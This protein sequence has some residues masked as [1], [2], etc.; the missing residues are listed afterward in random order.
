MC[1]HHVGESGGESSNGDF[2]DNGLSGR[3][4]DFGE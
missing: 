1:Y 4:D 3:F 2:G